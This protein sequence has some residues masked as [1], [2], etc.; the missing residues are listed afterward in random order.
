MGMTQD[1]K[2]EV[3]TIYEAYDSGLYKGI[4]PQKNNMV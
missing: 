4:Y 3:P 2:M 1:L